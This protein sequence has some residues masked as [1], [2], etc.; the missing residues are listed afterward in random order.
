MNIKSV[1][2]T[3]HHRLRVI[4]NEYKTPIFLL[5]LDYALCFIMYG[6]SCTEY[7]CHQFHS[8][9][10]CYK[11]QFITARHKKHLERW[12]N[13]P[14]NKPVLDNKK[15]FNST[16]DKF[17]TRKWISSSESIESICE[18]IDK[19]KIVIVKPLDL[20]GGKGIEKYEYSSL[21]KSKNFI[22]SLQGEYLF[23]EAISNNDEIAKFNSCTLSTI[24]LYTLVSNGKVEIIQTI[25]RLGNG[26]SVVDNFHSNGIVC[27]VDVNKGI[28]T[29]ATDREMNEFISHPISNHNLVG[30]E[31][32]KWF[33]LLNFTENLALS[34][35]S[36]RWTAWDIAITKTGFEVIEGNNYGDPTI[37]QMLT[38]KGLL[39]YLK[40]KI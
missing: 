19:Q 18:F 1:L 40:S 11:K 5:W 4:S 8:H 26:N 32:P 13:D 10:H 30:F 2:T 21:E 34:L 22:K 36:N 29:K 37:L 27:L 20:S 14:K 39:P 9:K 6:V 25:M 31:I 17:V 3:H 33:E 15:I 23:E 7:I 24:R 16:F 28:I 35:P 38:K 12:F